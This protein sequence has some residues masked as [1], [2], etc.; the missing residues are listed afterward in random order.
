[1]RNTLR[2]FLRQTIAMLGF[3]YYY[4]HFFH[5][6]YTKYIESKR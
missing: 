2:T 4:S 1:M 3:A 5:D 6:F